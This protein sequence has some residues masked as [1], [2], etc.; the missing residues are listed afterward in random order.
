MAEDKKI[1]QLNQFVQKLLASHADQW[2]TTAYVQE[3]MGFYGSIVP[4]LDLQ[5]DQSWIDLGCGAGNLIAFVRRSSQPMIIGVDNNPY[6]LTLAGAR[7]DQAGLATDGHYPYT[8]NINPNTFGIRI[9]PKIQSGYKLS[10]DKINLVV[11]D[12][13]ELTALKHYLNGDRVDLVT[14]VFCVAGT[15]GKYEPGFSQENI[16]ALIDPS[17]KESVHRMNQVNT[18][19]R[20]AVFAQA[21]KLLKPGGHLA[22]IDRIHPDSTD[23]RLTLDIPPEMELL[24]ARTQMF[25]QPDKEGL[26]ELVTQA[27]KITNQARFVFYKFQYQP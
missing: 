2:G 3:D 18:A 12:V 20:N 6:M 15:Q 13:R 11:D 8:I 19:T 26:T 4:F 24:E 1:A 9:E 14:S 21:P 25:E 17:S 5:D 7:F 27:G 22:Y 10:R 16:I 23:L